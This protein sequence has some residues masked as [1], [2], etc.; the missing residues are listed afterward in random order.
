MSD[1]EKIMTSL[2]G[3]RFVDSGA[4]ND[5][6]ELLSA[7][8]AIGS[9]ITEAAIDALFLDRWKQSGM[10]RAVSDDTVG[11]NDPLILLDINMAGQH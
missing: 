9:A 7:S 10:L 11:E 1:T 8:D 6:A 2:N 5:T 4:E 3:Y